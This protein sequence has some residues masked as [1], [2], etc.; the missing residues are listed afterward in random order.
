MSSAKSKAWMRLETDV[1]KF[2]GEWFARSSIST[3]QTLG[4]CNWDKLRDLL[5]EVR[6]KG[7]SIGGMSQLVEGEIQLELFL[8]SE[9]G[10]CPA[11]SLPI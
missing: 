3:L 4:E 7:G 2:R 8:S 11:I 9:D 6:N 5:P 10:K 1:D